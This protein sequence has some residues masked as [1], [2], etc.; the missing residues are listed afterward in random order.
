MDWHSLVA[1]NS[2]LGLVL[3][4]SALVGAITWDLITWSHG[5]LHSSKDKKA[6]TE[7]THYRYGSL[8][9]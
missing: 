2:Q 1:G 3:V 5:T 9:K 6:Q 4:F 7:D 8:W